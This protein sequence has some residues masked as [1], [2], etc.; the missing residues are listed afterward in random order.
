MNEELLKKLLEDVSYMRGRFDAE[1][2]QIKQAMEKS[3]ENTNQVL[4]L[5]GERLN[6]VENEMTGI[7]TKVGIFGALAG[8][9]SSAVI[10]IIV[11]VITSALNGK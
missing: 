11:S 3:A 7:K 1:I 5:Q 2:P 6:H 4:L 8:G 9:V 10:S